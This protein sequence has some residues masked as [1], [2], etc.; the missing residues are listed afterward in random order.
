MDIKSFTEAG[1]GSRNDVMYIIS[2][3]EK[4]VASQGMAITLHIA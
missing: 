4:G 2:N 1:I 3:F